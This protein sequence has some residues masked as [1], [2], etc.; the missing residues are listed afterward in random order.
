MVRRNG[1]PR[2]AK[3]EADPLAPFPPRDGPLES[4]VAAASSRITAASATA[5]FRK[6]E[7]GEPEAE[8]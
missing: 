2:S 3:I 7:R 5:A 8:P 1:E 6:V 4:R